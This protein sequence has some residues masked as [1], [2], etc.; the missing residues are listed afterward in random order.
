ME[1]AETVKKILQE[2]IVPELGKIKDENSKI[3]AVLEVTN[4]RLDDINVHLVDQS[5]RIDETNQ[6]V[7]EV[8]SELSARID[9]VRSE[10]TKRI[11]DIH[12]DLISRLDGNNARI[13]RFF[14][15]AATKE[16]HA[17]VD[18]RLAQLE[19]EMDHLR[20]RLAA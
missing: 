10:L 15:T 11:E 17:R 3:L 16:E 2:V 19:R 9:E 12:S 18:G 20:Q 14:L 6:R 13:D 5:R 1:I 7:D 4:K 8:R